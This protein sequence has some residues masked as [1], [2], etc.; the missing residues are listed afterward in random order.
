MYKKFN[1]GI[2][3]DKNGRIAENLTE[4]SGNT[5]MVKLGGFTKSFGIEAEIRQY[6]ELLL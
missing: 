4:L 3:L 1:L 5:P 2:G 6:M